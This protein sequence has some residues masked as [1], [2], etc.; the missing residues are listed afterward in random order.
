MERQQHIINKQVLEIH[1][2]KTA[3]AFAIQQK[4]S[5]LYRNQIV[6][7]MD[8]QLTA[9][10]G[11][12]EKKHYQID[13]L[14]IDLG[15]IR[16]E[17]IVRVFTEK[18]AR[19]L[20]SVEAQELSEGQEQTGEAQ[21]PQETPLKVLS[22]YLMTGFLPW[23]SRDTTKAYLLE[24]LDILLESPDNIFKALLG[25]L[26]Y[27]HV[28]L[29]RFLNTF[30][31]AQVLQSLQLLTA[32]PV[33]GLAKT[34]NELVAWTWK[35]PD[36]WSRGLTEFRIAKAFWGAAFEQIHTAKDYTSLEGHSIRQAIHTLGIVAEAIGDWPVYIRKW[37]RTEAAAIN[38]HL[39]EVR[40]LVGI[41]EIKY[42]DNSIWQQFF[43]HLS[44]VLNRPALSRVHPQLLRELR[45]LL[46]GVAEPQDKS[47]PWEGTGPDRLQAV[48]ETHLRPLV[49]HLR[50]LETVLKQMQPADAS[51]IVEKLH[52]E[53][54]NTD[55]ITVQ[56]AGL[57]LF[58]PFLQRFFE[59]LELTADTAFHDEAA[60]YKAVCVLQYLCDEMEEE[61]FFEGMLML[62]KVLCGIPL[63]DPVEPIR[64]S[65]EEKAMAEDL[66]QAVIARG[67]QWKNLTLPGF[68]TSYLQREGLLR[69]RDGHWLLQVKKE[70]Y[71]ITLEKLPWSFTVV[72]LPWMPEPLMVE[73][74]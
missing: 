39:Q 70:T 27:Q 33:K 61:E 74:V 35:D 40:S 53:F 52:S 30:T 10:Y 25:Q 5:T 44:K 51:N 17:D 45:Q 3:D 66:L 46:E 67:A 49:K 18:L 72:K 29:D 68:R 47:R 34:K 62:N 31:E 50:V 32:I 14:T 69:T 42:P 54:E 41:L 37:V 59:H 7:V 43:Q 38:S 58:W 6:P 55:F 57:V 9:R 71:D 64:L 12:D 1:L 15:E 48:T 26:R 56:N 73:W 16:M 4:L 60:Q 21:S 24:Q 19:T 28:Y 65:T 23:W 11:S 36:A 8:H 13:T 63:E 22:H 20:A 2:P